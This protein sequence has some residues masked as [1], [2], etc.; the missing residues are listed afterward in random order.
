MYK[1]TNTLGWKPTDSRNNS[2]LVERVLVTRVGLS[3]HR[4]EKFGLAR[5]R[6]HDQGH[7]WCLVLIGLENPTRKARTLSA[8]PPSVHL[9]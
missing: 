3:S 4:M 9:D 6:R 5:F 1:T 2:Y 7:S 8:A